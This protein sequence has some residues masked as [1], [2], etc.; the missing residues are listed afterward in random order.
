MMVPLVMK[1][2]TASLKGSLAM[3]MVDRALMRC[4][5]RDSAS[6]RS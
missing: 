4:I 3:V 2:M 1:M 5:A 6:A